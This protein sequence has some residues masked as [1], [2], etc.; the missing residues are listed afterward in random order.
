MA[1]AN[2]TMI[3]PEHENVTV[4][5]FQYFKLIKIAY[6]NDNIKDV[7]ELLLC[8]STGLENNTIIPTRH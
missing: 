8:N 5:A 4:L 7:I 2:R 3:S 6:K 1:R